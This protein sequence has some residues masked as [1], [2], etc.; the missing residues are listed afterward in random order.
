MVFIGK[1]ALNCM[2][3]VVAKQ[4]LFVEKEWYQSS[5]CNFI[6]LWKLRSVV[7]LTK[8]LIDYP[9]PEKH[10]HRYPVI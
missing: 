1:Q 7:Q 3:L 10:R 6:L 9:Q 8:V 4:P 5:R 2:W